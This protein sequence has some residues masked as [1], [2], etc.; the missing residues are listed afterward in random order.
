MAW[1]TCSGMIVKSNARVKLLPM[2]SLG[3]TFAAPAVTC[4]RVSIYHGHFRDVWTLAWATAVPG[5]WRSSCAAD[6]SL[7]ALLITARGEAPHGQFLSSSGT[8]LL[9]ICSQTVRILLDVAAHVGGKY[10]GQTHNGGHVYTSWDRLAGFKS[11]H[12]PP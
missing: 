2:R 4:L 12:L 9:T 5:G 7:D 11:R 6:T 1:L 8:V 3:R 10:A